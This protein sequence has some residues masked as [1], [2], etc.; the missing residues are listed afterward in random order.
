MSQ[1]RSSWRPFSSADDSDKPFHSCMLDLEH[2]R[3]RLRPP[4]MHPAGIGLPRIHSRLREC[5][6]D[7]VY[8]ADADDSGTPYHK[9][10]AEVWEGDGLFLGWDPA[11]GVKACAWTGRVSISRML[12]GGKA[13]RSETACAG[14][15]VRNGRGLPW[16]CL[17]CRLSCGAAAKVSSQA[18]RPEPCCFPTR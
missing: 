1:R 10:S 17:V 15:W 2:L 5:S 9:D 13:R 11:R 8:C 6:W 16:L 7:S 14:S 3:P 18:L 12:R 4:E